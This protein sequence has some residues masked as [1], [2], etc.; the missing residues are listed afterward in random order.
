[1]RAPMRARPSSGP[2]TAPAIQALDF[3]GGGGGGT[4]DGEGDGL[5]FGEGE[6]EVV[7]FRDGVDAA[8]EGLLR[9]KVIL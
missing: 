8:T 5:G 3:A 7:D 6:G 2:I 9:K 1:M 4:G